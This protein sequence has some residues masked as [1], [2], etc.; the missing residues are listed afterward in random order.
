MYLFYIYIFTHT[1]EITPT[2]TTSQYTCRHRAPP[3]VVFPWVH[4]CVLH[5]ELLGEQHEGIHWPL[6]LSGRGTVTSCRAGM[7]AF[8]WRLTSRV[9]G[10]GTVCRL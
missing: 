8:G 5:P 4:L 7:L 2:L 3:P 9:G 6:A 10:T 1:L